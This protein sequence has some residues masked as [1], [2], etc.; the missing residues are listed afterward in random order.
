MDG[1]RE[2]L[3]SSVENPNSELWFPA[4][5][6][7]LTTLEWARLRREVGLT[8]FT[9]GT[10]RAI[11]RTISAPRTLISTI[12]I[13]SRCR[14]SLEGVEEWGKPYRESGINFYSVEAIH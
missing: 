14:I 4:I 5:A 12:E 6:T 10:A 2:K 7:D 11:R 3:F 1:L 13:S 8:Q 9:Y